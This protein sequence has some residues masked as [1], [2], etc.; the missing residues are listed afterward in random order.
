M[1]LH[2]PSVSWLFVRKHVQISSFCVLVNFVVGWILS[3]FANKGLSI[4]SI[5][6]EVYNMPVAATGIVFF[7]KCIIIVVS[8]YSCVYVCFGFLT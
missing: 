4:S 5:L 2:N 8:G 1:I 7:D 3:S 6:L